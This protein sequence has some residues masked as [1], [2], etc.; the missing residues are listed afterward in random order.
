MPDLKYDFIVDETD[1]ST[2]HGVMIGLVGSGKDVLDVG[3]ATG[4]LAEQLRQR[5]NTV[6]GI[7][8][9]PHAA[10]LARQHADP[11]IVGDLEDPEIFSS[12]SDS[13]FDVL[14]F[15]DVLEHLK[16]P[17]GVLRR[18]RRILRPA[19]SIVI[20]VPNI[21]HG[22]VRLSLLQGR[23]DYQRLGLLDD[24]HLRFFTRKSL[25]AMLRSTGFVA[26]DVRNT[27]VPLFKTELG[28]EAGDFPQELLDQ[29]S[30]S[31]D[32]TTYQFI[33]RAVLDDAVAVSEDMAWQL[34]DLEV[35][36]Q[37]ARDENVRLSG[38]VDELTS[39][40]HQKD[41]DLADS[42]AALDDAL[43][44]SAQDAA[45]ATRAEAELQALESTRLFRT[46]APAR[47]IYRKLRQEPR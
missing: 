15:G 5:G 17:N 46:T 47:R 34:K 9:D 7:E 43:T 33:A 18:A 22:D 26:V 1:Q 39:T 13:S 23:F 40:L 10:Q 42:A 25:R 31:P 4:Y 30:Q 27:T 8:M 16:D 41:G 44:A 12:F 38:L 2:S 3:C 20:S 37:T 11:V 45:R 14:V 32:A 21:A 24:T 36:L 6:S 28:V 35:A 19:G 29:I